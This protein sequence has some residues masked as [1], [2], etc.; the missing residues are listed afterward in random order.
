MKELRARWIVGFQAFWMGLTLKTRA[1]VPMIFYV[2]GMSLI[3]KGCW[4]AWHPLGWI[5][6]GGALAWLSVQYEKIT[7]AKAEAEKLEKL[8]EKRPVGPG[9]R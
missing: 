6:G 3:A 9:L 4:E 1:E 2:V 7:T 5:Y 8:Y